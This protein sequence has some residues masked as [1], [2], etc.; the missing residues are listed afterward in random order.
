LKI[1]FVIESLSK[2]GAERVISVLSQEMERLGHEVTII[3]FTQKIAYSYGGKLSSLN[4]PLPQKSGFMKLNLLKV[5]WHRISAL[6]K[7]IK[8]CNPDKVFSFMEVSSII[9]ILA[10]RK[11]IACIRVDLGFLSSRIK[12]VMKMLYPFASGIV[13]NAQAQVKSL[14]GILSHRNVRVI[15]N[16]LNLDYIRIQRQ[17]DLDYSCPFI[18]AVGRL[19]RQKRFDLLI[20]AFARSAAKNDLDLVILGAGGEF[21]KLQKIAQDLQV[22]DRVKFLGVVDNPYSYMR[23][24]LFFVLSSD[25][26]GF[27]NALA[28]ALACGAAVISTN[29]PTG[30]S[31]L[32]TNGLNGRLVPIGD[33]DVLTR[34]MDELYHGEKLQIQFKENAH[35]SV[36]SLDVSNIVKQF[37]SF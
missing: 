35:E 33:V 9:S 22:E 32:I 25:F 16:P 34:V 6:K 31:E 37:L 24:C 29:C 1:L 28:E 27:P 5:Y 2:G 18:L 26:E 7:I 3:I 8:Q 4:L 14:E 11:T 17:K 30:P 10:T 12:F 21:A 20:E 13:C 19:E 15:Y 23:R 36:K